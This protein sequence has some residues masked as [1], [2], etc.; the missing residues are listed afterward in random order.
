MTI[1]DAYEPDPH[2][3]TS[4]PAEDR[5][6]ADLAMLSA[7]QKKS[8]RDR[9]RMTVIA[10]FVVFAFLLLSWRSEVNADR[11]HRNG[12]RISDTQQIT[13]ESTREVLRKYNQQQDD[14]IA[15]ERGNTTDPAAI[16]NARIRAYEVGRIDP[17][18]ICDNR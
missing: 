6:Y 1:S 8:D 5:W 2:T 11:I 12:E 14:L 3:P 18:P 17:L 7:A 10:G 15:I 16:R 13:C 4:S 9:K